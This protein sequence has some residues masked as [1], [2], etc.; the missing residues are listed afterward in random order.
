MDNLTIEIMLSP[1]KFMLPEPHTKL[2]NMEKYWATWEK[3]LCCPMQ[4]LVA[5]GNQSYK[6]GLGYNCISCQQT[7][8]NSPV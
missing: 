5:Q 6:I 8:F 4:F 1:T 3:N 2:K 7:C